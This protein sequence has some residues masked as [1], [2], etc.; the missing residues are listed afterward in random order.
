MVRSGEESGKLNQTFLYLADYL[1]REY[2]LRQKTKSA[3]VS[4]F[5]IA[6]FIVIMI[7]MFVFIIPKMSAMFA[8][9]GGAT[10]CYSDSSR[11]F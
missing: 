1:D 6:T 4:I 3:D 5:V 8:G 11:Y 10:A 7:V 2:E 9:R